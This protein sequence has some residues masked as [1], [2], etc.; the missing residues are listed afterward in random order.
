M[1]FG[2][3]K[4]DLVEVSGLIDDV[5]GE[6]VDMRGE[7]YDFNGK[8]KPS[9][10]IKVVIK[11]DGVEE[12]ATEYYRVGDPNVIVP[13]ADGNGCGPAPGSNAKGYNN[14]SKGGKLLDAFSEFLGANTPAKFDGFRGLR[15]HWAR[16]PFDMTGIKR[17]AGSKDVTILLPTKLLGKAGAATSTGGNGKA[18]SEAE[19]VDVIVVAVK[20]LGGSATPAAVSK[21]VFKAE[22]KNPN[23]KDIVKLTMDKTWL[24]QDSHPWVFDGENL[25]VVG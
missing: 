19:A 13:D 5:D 11:P 12:T 15:F 10:C 3:K 2:L 23:V 25:Q 24:A 21:Q 9:T 16:K 18:T 17:E 22:V 14:K 8:Q 20:A 1:S 4:E 7:I 6:I